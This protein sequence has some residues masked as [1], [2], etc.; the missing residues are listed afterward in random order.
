M[1][2]RFECKLIFTDDVTGV[3]AED[4]NSCD[5]IAQSIIDDFKREL[6]PKGTVVVEDANIRIEGR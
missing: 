2:I 1:K 6:S 4:V 3:C 5:I